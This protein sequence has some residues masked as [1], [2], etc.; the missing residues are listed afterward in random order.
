MRKTSKVKTIYQTVTEY[1]ADDGKVF[2]SEAECKAYVI[3]LHSDLETEFYNIETHNLDIPFVDWDS[4]S[5]I[6]QIF[7]LKSERDYEIL[8]TWL[9]IREGVTDWYGSDPASYPAVFF[10]IGR[11]NFNIGYHL[12]QSHVDGLRKSA[13]LI[14]KLLKK[15]E[16]K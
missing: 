10:V 6:S 8:Q 9:E 1:I 14:S 3:K 11:D 15:E 16:L 5:D 13:T 7:I 2:E 12:N 4:E